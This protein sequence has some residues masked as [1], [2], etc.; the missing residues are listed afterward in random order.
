VVALYRSWWL[1][2]PVILIAL[3]IASYF[4]LVLPWVNKSIS[5]QYQQLTGHQLQHDKLDIHLLSCNFALNNLKDS[6]NLWQINSLKL[7]VACWK[8]FQERA[9]IV[10]HVQISQLS[11][12][13]LQSKSGVWNFNDVLE[14]IAHNTPKPKTNNKHSPVA[15]KKLSVTQSSLTTNVLAL[16]D[17][18]LSATP[19]ELTVLDLDLRRDTTARFLV[20]ATLNKTT[21]CKLSGNIDPLNMSGVINFSITKVPFVWFDSQ[22]KSY[23]ALDVLQGELNTDGQLRIDKGNLQ[24]IASNGRLAELKVRPTTMDQDAVHWKSFEWKSADINIPKKT[25]NIP[26]AVLTELDGQFIITKDRTT[27][28]QAVIIPASNSASLGQ[29]TKY[30]GTAEQPWQFGIDELRVDKAAIGFYDQ[31]LKPSFTVIV[32]QFSGL[33][34]NINTNAEKMAEFHLAGNVDGYA[35][36]SLDGKA[37]FFIPQPQMEALFS[38]KKM[39]MGALSPYSA[40]YAGWRIKKGLLSVD[41]DYH[42]DQGKILGKNHVVIDHLEFGEKVRSP[43]VIDLPLR[44]GLSLLTD[45]HGIAILDADITG[46]PNDPQFDLKATIQRA[47]RN[48]FKKVLTAPFRWL[49]SLVDTK[50]DLGRIEFTPGESQLS[51]SAKEKLALLHEAMNK[52]PK[53]HLTIRGNYDAERDLKALQEEQVKSALQKVGLSRESND[54]QNADWAKALDAQYLAKGLSNSAADSTQKFN[55]LA[56]LEIV[57]PERFLRLVRERGQ[58]VKQYFVLQLGADG[59]RLFLESDPECNEKHPCNTSDVQFTLED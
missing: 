8:S 13:P 15:I 1:R 21:D 58:A 24:Q 29:G 10:N 53:M 37:Q 44:L 42:Y 6:A 30:G 38:F 34:T 36:V 31:S 14:H 39:D 18:A 3:I 41:L 2:I 11:G 46:D 16:N 22:I 55:E 47:L 51:Q 52:R 40:E 45:E 5:R 20:S 54:T 32:Q 48:T 23:L 50:E 19:F 28:V 59:A 56:A 7:D 35:P 9:L 12:N 4:L 57:D 26:Q 27:N 49:A 17:L 25:I 43:H 33:I